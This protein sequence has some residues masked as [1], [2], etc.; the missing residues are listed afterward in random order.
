MGLYQNS[1][2]VFQNVSNIFFLC[3]KYHFTDP[4]EPNSIPLIVIH[5]ANDPIEGNQLE[6]SCDVGEPIE[7]S[8]GLADAN[9]TPEEEVEVETPLNG[10]SK[11]L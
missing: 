3:N 1:L 9:E 2:S 8:T 7:N 5:A 11:C 10:K 4:E 6:E